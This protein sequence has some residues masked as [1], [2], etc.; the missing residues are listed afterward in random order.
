MSGFDASDLELLTVGFFAEILR[1]RAGVALT[2]RDERDPVVVCLVFEPNLDCIRNLRRERLEVLAAII[3]DV[4]IWRYPDGVD[5]TVDNA[6]ATGLQT[7]FRRQQNLAS[8]RV[9]RLVAL[10][11][12]ELRVAEPLIAKA[13]DENPLQRTRLSF[14]FRQSVFVGVVSI[15]LVT[16]LLKSYCL[17]IFPTETAV[18]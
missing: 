2:L 12:A 14:E 1:Q 10:D 9:D 13:G 15:F 8:K 16:A 17:D 3:V 4:G 7:L 18:R 11:T 5:D 6:P